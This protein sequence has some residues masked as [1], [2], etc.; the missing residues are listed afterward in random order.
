MENTNTN[1]P[2]HCNSCGSTEYTDLYGCEG[3]ELE[4]YSDC[5]NKRLCYDNDLAAHLARN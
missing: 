4:G 5:C 2:T 3:E 1:D